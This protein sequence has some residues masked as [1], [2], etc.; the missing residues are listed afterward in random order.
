MQHML[1][2]RHKNMKYTGIVTP[3]RDIFRSGKIIRY[4]RVARCWKIKNSRE[5]FA[6]KGLL[7]YESRPYGLA[8][9]N[10]LKGRHIPKGC[11]LKRKQLGYI[12]DF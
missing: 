12:F 2:S 9:K 10:T 1:T 3:C 8:Q 7:F 5:I 11:V 6:A 4:N